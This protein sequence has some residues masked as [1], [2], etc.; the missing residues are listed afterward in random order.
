[1]QKEV[2]ERTLAE[3]GDKNFSAL[4]LT[5]GEYFK[6]REL[7]YLGPEHFSPPPKVESLAIE[8]ERK[9]L[10]DPIKLD[11]Y[12]KT[13]RMAFQ[14]RRKTIRNSLK[15]IVTPQELENLE[16]DPG[17]RPQTL[18]REDFWRVVEFKMQSAE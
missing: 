12:E 14:Q 13:V 6:A 11:L 18:S 8:I 3:P 5:F 10:P 4:T 17:A 15:P 16:I 2:S 1:M 7:F 9:K